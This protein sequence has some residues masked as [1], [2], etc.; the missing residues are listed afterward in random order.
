MKTA[1]V[2]KKGWIVIPA[3]IRREMN[4]QP[5][6]KMA[7]TKRD[8]VITITPAPKNPIEAAYGMLADDGPSLA[9]ALLRERKREMA[10]EEAKYQRIFGKEFSI[11]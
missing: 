1:T 5:G 6:D 10:L 4:I 8:D 11:E 7:I 3:K 9:D 2:S